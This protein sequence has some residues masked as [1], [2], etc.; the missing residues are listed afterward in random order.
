M[1]SFVWTCWFELNRTNRPVFEWAERL[2]WRCSPPGS[3]SAHRRT[4]RTAGRRTQRWRRSRS[5]ARPRSPGTRQRRTRPR[6]G[7]KLN[8]N[9]MEI[10]KGVD[11]TWSASPVILGCP[12]GTPRWSLSPDLS[13]R[14]TLASPAPPLVQCPGWF[15]PWTDFWPGWLSQLS[16]L[17]C[18]LGPQCRTG[19]R[20]LEQGQRGGHRVNE[21]VC[22]SKT[23]ERWL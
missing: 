14:G 10:W 4:W 6:G 16:T 22:G 1:C 17:S 5:N 7:D 9:R 8:V 11:Q 18:Y 3:D 13:E 23:Y 15:H 2:P 19:E 21:A 12:C 20:H